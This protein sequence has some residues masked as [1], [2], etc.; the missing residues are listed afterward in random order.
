MAPGSGNA[1]SSSVRN[2]SY[3]LRLKMT[4]KVAIVIVLP[5]VSAAAA[6]M[7]YASSVRS[8]LVGTVLFSDLDLSSSE[9]IVG[10]FSVRD[11][12]TSISR[13]TVSI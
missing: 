12:S 10:R 8:E 2:D 7:L 9:N 6:N 5:V 13:F 1:S 11:L 4:L 3:I